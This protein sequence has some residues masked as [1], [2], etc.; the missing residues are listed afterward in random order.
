MNFSLLFSCFFCH[1][2]FKQKHMKFVLACFPLYLSTHS[3]SFFFCSVVSSRNQWISLFSMF[4]YFVV[5][6]YVFITAASTQHKTKLLQWY[7]RQ[8]TCALHIQSIFFFTYWIINGS[9]SWFILVVYDSFGFFYSTSFVFIVC[10]FLS[11]YVCYVLD[12]IVGG[13]LTTKISI[14]NIFECHRIITECCIVCT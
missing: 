5:I 10:F 12:V 9:N 3:F 14:Q 1:L 7:A 11:L 13:K 8:W 6:L 4:L 2:F